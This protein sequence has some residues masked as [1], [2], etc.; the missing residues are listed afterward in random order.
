MDLALNNLQMLICHKT[1]QTKP[2]LNKRD[3][4]DKYE[5]T[6]RNKFYVLQEKIE[7]HTPNDKYGTFV[8]AHLEA[9]AECIP[10]KQRAKPNCLI[11]SASSCRWGLTSGRF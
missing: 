9:A 5:S 6:L 3:I 10:T 2:L 8:N 1:K 4:R 11:I 7:T